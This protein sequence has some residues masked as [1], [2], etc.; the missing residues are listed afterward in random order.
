MTICVTRSFIYKN[1]DTS[2]KGRQ[3]AL[4]FFIYTKTRT[5]CVIR[6]SIDFL[7]LAGIF[8]SK[9]IYFALYFYLGRW[10]DKKVTCPRKY[11]AKGSKI[12]L[13]GSEKGPCKY[14]ARGAKF[15]PI[16]SHSSDQGKITKQVLAAGKFCRNIKSKNKMR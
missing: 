7:K 6:F 11:L 12:P 1:P 8:I 13:L 14:S 4:R 10:T 9:K 5:L 2:K 16:V 3:F 15:Q